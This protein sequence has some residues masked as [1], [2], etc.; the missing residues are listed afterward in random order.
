MLQGKQLYIGVC[1]CKKKV[2]DITGEE[3]AYESLSLTFSDEKQIVKKIS[4]EHMKGFI[5]GGFSSRFWFLKNY[6]NI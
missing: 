5:Y 1:K 6:I 2:K 3:I 4:S